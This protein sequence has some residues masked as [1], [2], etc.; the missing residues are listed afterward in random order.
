MEKQCCNKIENNSV[1]EV[2]RNCILNLSILAEKLGYDKEIW[3]KN[4]VGEIREGDDFY[5]VSMQKLQDMVVSLSNKSNSA[6]VEL[7]NLLNDIKDALHDIQ[8]PV[9][10]VRS[11]SEMLLEMAHECDDDTLDYLHKIHNASIRITDMLNDIKDIM[12]L[13]KKKSE[14][15]KIIDFQQIIKDVEDNLHDIITD[16]NAKIIINTKNMPIF[17]SNVLRWIRIFQNLVLNAIIYNVSDSPIINIWFEDN[18]IFIKDNGMGIP[19]EKIEIIFE[20]FTRLSDRQE[21]AAGTG[22]G[23]FMCRK[24]LSMDGCLINVDNSDFSGTIFIIS[25][26][27]K[28]Y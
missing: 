21:M 14:I 16:R 6:E 20:L 3:I 12:I 17:R 1:I 9:R 19:E 4:A 27:E 25:L 22:A 5:C 8:A 15:I 13:G 2:C 7:T 11:F 10:S 24:F 26:P 28:T 18:K 23:L